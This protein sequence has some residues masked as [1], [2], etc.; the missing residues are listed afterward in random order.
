[1]NKTEPVNTTLSASQIRIAMQLLNSDANGMSYN[2]TELKNYI[3]VQ[4]VQRQGLGIGNGTKVLDNGI[5]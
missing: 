2:L 1:M 5:Y 3:T 4:A